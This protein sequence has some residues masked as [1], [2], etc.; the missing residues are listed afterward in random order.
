MR[1]MSN[2]YLIIFTVFFELLIINNAKADLDLNWQQSNN[3]WGILTQIEHGTGTLE[4]ANQL[5]N[6]TYGKPEG[7]EAGLFY[8]P[9]TNNYEGLELRELRVDMVGYAI[10]SNPILPTI[11]A[12]GGYGP[13]ATIGGK[14]LE[15]YGG[16]YQARRVQAVSTE[17][18]DRRLLENYQ[19]NF[20]GLGF[21]DQFE[22]ND[23]ISNIPI[24]LEIKTRHTQFTTST[25]ENN[26]Y[27]RWK[28]NI[29]SDFTKVTPE[30]L[31]NIN[32]FL[33]LGP[34]PSPSFESQGLIWDYLWK[35]DPFSDLWSMVGIGFRIELKKTLGAY[36]QTGLFAGYLG[37]E[38]GIQPLPRFK[39]NI[40]T[41]EL[42]TS[43]AF[44]AQG[45]RF[46]GAEAGIEF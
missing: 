23:L 4:S 13:Q 22:F 19:V 27:H 1:T 42:E 2:P 7:A 6:Q 11:Y 17:I 14:F 10:S 46:W 45:I 20:W 31:P 30:F 43:S 40:K 3:F 38:L 32:G 36:V 25:N 18:I 44:Q 35:V 5:L 37:A 12:W 33:I 9:T 28:I 29:L 24:Q 39:V 21:H 16:I 34:Q 26:W 41:Y 8:R 15:V